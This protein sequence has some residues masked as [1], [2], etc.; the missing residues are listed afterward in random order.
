[1]LLGRVAWGL[2]VDGSHLPGILDPALLFD[3][4]HVLGLEYLHRRWNC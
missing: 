2:G 3:Q 4:D 1:M